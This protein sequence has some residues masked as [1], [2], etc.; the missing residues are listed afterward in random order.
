V[1][2]RAPVERRA[3]REDQSSPAEEEIEKMGWI[4]LDTV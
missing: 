2:G 3:G 4:V 1:I